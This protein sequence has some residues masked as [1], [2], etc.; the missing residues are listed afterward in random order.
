MKRAHGIAPNAAT[1]KP[2][3]RSLKP[4]RTEPT[5]SSST[6]PKAKKRK[7]DHFLEENTAEDDDEGFGT[8]K[9]EPVVAKT[10]QLEVKAE[11]DKKHQPG[12]LSLDETANLLQYYD[13]PTQYAAIGMG[14]ND[15]YNG[16]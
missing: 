11:V 9:T 7:T 2:A 10:E 3:P 1:V 16:D 5:Q 13:T 12:Q 14:M 8:V 6:T 4:V 15:G